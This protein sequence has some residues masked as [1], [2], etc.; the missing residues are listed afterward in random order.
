MM[1]VVSSINL[2]QNVK[3]VDTV[4]SEM[5]FKIDINQ[6]RILK[7]NLIGLPHLKDTPSPS[8]SQCSRCATSYALSGLSGYLYLSAIALYLAISR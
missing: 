4:E 6:I 2:G 5:K 3:N 7:H 1:S 8:I